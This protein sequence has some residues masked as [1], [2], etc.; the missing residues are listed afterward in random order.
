MAHQG[1]FIAN[2]R[3]SRPLLVATAMTFGYAAPVAALAS[4][5]PLAAVCVGAFVAGL[6]G[7]I[8]QALFAATIQWLIPV[9]L[10]GRVSAW[11]TLGAF[12]L[13]P[14]A[15]AAAGPVGSAVG[16]T[17]VLA[18]SAAWQVASVALTLLVPSIRSIRSDAEKG[19]IRCTRTEPS[20][21][22]HT[23]RGGG[24]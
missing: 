2:R 7:S 24:I 19:P 6:G 10:L 11:E 16:V 22:S 21:C 12:A 15:L 3:P 5:L 4:P 20:Y 13:G 1:L 8:G 18:F 17:R 14:L 9:E 23:S